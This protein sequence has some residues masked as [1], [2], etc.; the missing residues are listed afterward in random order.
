MYEN[1]FS[2]FADDTFLVELKIG[3]A[4]RVVLVLFELMFGLKVNFNKSILV[5]VNVNLQLLII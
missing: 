5:G 3:R 4:M 1:I 2:L